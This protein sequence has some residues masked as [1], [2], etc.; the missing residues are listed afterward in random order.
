[1]RQIEDKLSLFVK[2]QFPAFYREEGGM[3]QVFLEAYY[4]YLEQEGK[5]IDFARNL[6]EYKDIDSTTAQFLDHFKTTFLSQLP[7]LVRA[8]DRLTIKNIMDFYRAK[9]TPRAVQLLF[10]LLFDESIT[11]NYPSDDVLKPSASQFKRPRYVE[12]YA[13][14]LD[15]LISLQGIEILGGTSGA[16]AFVESI[17][18]KLLNKVKVH[19][20]TLSNLRGNFLRGEI[21]TK[22]V[23]GNTD[24]MPIVTG[25]LS[26][27]TITLGGSDNQIGDTFNVI[28]SS[29]KQG[30]ARVTAIADA[31]GLVDF[32]LANGGFGFSLDGN[33]T[34]TDVNDQNIQVNNVINAAQS[35]SNVHIILGANAHTLF[36]VG[37][38]ITVDTSDAN[39]VISAI[40]NDTNTAG[41]APNTHIIVNNMFGLITTNDKIANSTNG[42]TTISQVRLDDNLLSLRVA[43][44]EFTRFETVQQ[45]V[46]QISTLSA[47][48][49]NNALLAFEA[50]NDD[51]ILPTVQGLTSI[52]DVVA[53]GYIINNTIGTGTTDIKV[54]VVSGS[55][56]DQ[57]TA[58]MDLISNSHTFEVNEEIDEESLVT[59]TIADDGAN[60]Q[61]I[62]STSDI[63]SSDESGANGVVASITNS[64]VMSMNGVFGTFIAN[65]N[66]FVAGAPG[67]TANVTD[68]NITNSGANGVVSSAN[69]TH[70]VINEVVGV[71]ND[72]K[73][74]KGRRTNAIGITNTVST[75]G[76]SDIRLNGNNSVNCV[77]DTTSNVSVTAQV[78]GSNATNIGFKTT[79]YSNGIIATFH[80]SPAAFIKGRESNTYANVVTVG[81]GSGADFKIGTLENEDPITIYTDFVGENNVANVS[82]LDCVID[83]GNSGIG[84]LDSIEVANGQGGAD[85]TVGQHINYTDG[86]AGGGLPTVN[87]VA[88][89]SSVNA[90]GGI[91]TATVITQGSGFY[92]N[93]TP[94]YPNYANGSVNDSANV[95][96][97]FDFGYGFPKDQDGD[98]TT[99][100]DKVLTRISGNV[101]TISSFSDI[102]PGNNYNFDPFVS[103]YTPGIAKY[104]RR[105]I[106]VNLS[107]MGTDDAGA[108]KDFIIGETINQTVTFQSQV[109]TASGGF[110]LTFNN[111]ASSAS[112]SNSQITDLIG[113]S[114]LQTVSNTVT[115]LGD[116]TSGNSTSVTVRNLRIRTEVDNSP[117]QNSFTF[118]VS[119]NIPF[120]ED[121]ISF[122]DPGQGDA[123]IS[124]VAATV[125]GLGTVSQSEVAKGQ[126]YKFNNNNDGTGD[127]GIRR[128]SFS[129][130]FNDSGTIQGATST[131][132]GT[133]DS[134]Y[135]DDA[136]RPIGDNA[137]VIADARAANGIVTAVEVIDSGFGYQHNANLTLR[138]TN[139]AQQIVVSGLANVATTGIGPGYWAS[140]ES[141]L[142]TKY[143]HDN[144]FYQSHSYVIESGLSLN[145]YR[146]ILLKSTHIAGTKLFGRVFKESVANVAVHVSNNQIEKLTG[147][148]NDESFT[149]SETVNT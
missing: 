107:G 111:G 4:E 114:V 30:R 62:F 45:D 134:L 104:D 27:I 92:S 117:A 59:I 131:A 57:K 127:V 78:I 56:M 140:R 63:V 29:G 38:S 44:A 12:V 25:S 138:S 90:T 80:N 39:G 24:D 2:E 55:F 95:T 82:Y 9:G 72:D 146:D 65:D 109:L 94:T 149:V 26:D 16:K 52:G 135:E 43:N 21:I 106:I 8:D 37:D 76:A 100:L 61:S 147:Y 145:K 77:V 99:I 122:G 40:G 108:Y 6:L 88:N 22:S 75:T 115:T 144:D 11:V 58:T 36:A 103:V 142:N 84:F 48:T 118:D 15:K 98:F 83:G 121:A 18:T 139:T 71:F 5:T 96:S 10:R 13:S 69:L 93:A 143:I 129:V 20:L 74:I 50:A 91:L 41:D 120:T 126:V 3:F 124:A 148:A 89:I 49:F 102:N 34:F 141:F 101:G 130:G 66:I 87:A 86:G 17:S 35:V 79:R 128:L 125:T 110:T 42:N 1:M 64:T 132:G 112:A 31:T 136:T 70:I 54:A 105:D 123:N 116:I 51:D 14:D 85:Y 73:K 7:G 113:T 119:N 23:D 137:N 67:T 97:N 28:A 46:E 133:I 32:E 19:V 81:S 53:N 68:I 33:V 60:L 47:T